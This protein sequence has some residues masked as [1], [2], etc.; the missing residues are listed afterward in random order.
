[1]YCEYEKKTMPL[2]HLPLPSLAFLDVKFESPH[3]FQNSLAS[4]PKFSPKLRRFFIRMPQL[5]DTFSK[6]GPNY[7]CRW[8]NLCS[9]ICP[10]VA[11]DLNAL[12]HLTQMP[13]LTRLTFALSNTLPASDS[14][15]LF[16]NLHELTLHSKSLD[17]ISRLFSHLLSRKLL[18]TL[19]TLLPSRNSPLSSPVF[20]HPMPITPSRAC[21]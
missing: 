14:P 10:Q 15:H 13:A 19:T 2:L 12:A 4:F 20:R 16:S 7:I 21:S 17:P 11:L 18:P 1:M 3:S 8:R 6:I 9:L 5:K